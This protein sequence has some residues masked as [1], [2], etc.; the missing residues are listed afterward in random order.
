MRAHRTIA[1]QVF[2]RDFPNCKSVRTSQYY[3]IEI[4]SKASLYFASFA[5]EEERLVRIIQPVPGQFPS[6]D[7]LAGYL[8]SHQITFDEWGYRIGPAH[9][10][11]VTEMLKE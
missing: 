7:S 5:G 2:R 10:R 11:A 6:R 3:R 9:W 1:Y 4:R 8:D